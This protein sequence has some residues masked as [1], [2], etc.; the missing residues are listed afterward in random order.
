MR[1]Q[2]P[3]ENVRFFKDITSLCYMQQK[4]E[5]RTVCSVLNTQHAENTATKQ[6][7]NK[8]TNKPCWKSVLPHFLMSSASP[9]K[10]IAFSCQTY[11]I[12]AV[13]P[14]TAMLL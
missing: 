13:Q 7:K 8:Q 14:N 10:T 1:H 2:K 12:Q 3:K 11:E 5:Y 9:V 4:P 6:N